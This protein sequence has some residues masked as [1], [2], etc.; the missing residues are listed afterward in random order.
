MNLLLT[1]MKRPRGNSRGAFGC[2]SQYMPP[3]GTLE[4]S[5]TLRE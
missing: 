1:H 4:L 2:Y 5:R 3:F